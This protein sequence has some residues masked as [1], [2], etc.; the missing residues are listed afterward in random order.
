MQLKGVFC[1]GGGS[2]YKALGS[3]YGA[4]GSPYRPSVP[5]T[6]ALFNCLIV[7]H[8][9]GFNCTGPRGA[10]KNIGLGRT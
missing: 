8:I 10:S 2:C 1:K 6:G 9:P 7:G 4:I 5:H 3:W